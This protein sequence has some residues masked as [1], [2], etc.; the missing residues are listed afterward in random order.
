MLGTRYVPVTV[1]R[2]LCSVLVDTGSTVTL[3]RLD[4]VPGWTQ[5][6]PTTV[7]LRS[8]TG[9]LAPLKGNG[10]LTVIVGERSVRHPV[11]IAAVQDPCILGSDFLRATGCQLDLEKGT[12]SFQGGPAVTMAPSETPAMLPVRLI[13]PA[14]HTAE[15]ASSNPPSLFLPPVTPPQRYLF[16]ATSR[17]GSFTG[18]AHPGPATPDGG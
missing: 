15:T 8:V 4:V 3:V 18:M 17:P 2:V 9:D 11:W 16:L 10:M 13:T 6:E 5:F 14:V 7:Q 1:E 12:V